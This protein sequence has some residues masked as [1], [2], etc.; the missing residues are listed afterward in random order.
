ML[1]D[2]LY[3]NRAVI[4]ECHIHNHNLLRIKHSQASESYKNDMLDSVRRSKEVLTRFE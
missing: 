3:I 1:G 4:C 2:F